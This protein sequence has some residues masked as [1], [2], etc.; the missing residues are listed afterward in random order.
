MFALR[1]SPNHILTK[2]TGPIYEIEPL[3]DPPSLVRDD[4]KLPDDAGE[5]P[6]SQGRGWR[7]EPRL[8]NL[9]SKVETPYHDNDLIPTP[10][11]S[12]QSGWQ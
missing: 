9:L 5:I 3:G 11:I 4:L 2:D 7:F 12:P 1:S 6:K 8:R 10:I